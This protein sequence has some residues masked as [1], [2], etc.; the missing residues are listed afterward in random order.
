[1]KIQAKTRCLLDRHQA[2]PSAVIYMEIYIEGKIRQVYAL[3]VKKKSSVEHVLVILINTVLI[4][5]S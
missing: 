5:C 3:A 2:D 1:M 4:N